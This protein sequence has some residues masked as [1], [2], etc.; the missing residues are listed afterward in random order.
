VSRARLGA[1]QLTRLRDELS[2]RDLGIVAQVAELRLMDARQIEA[3]HFGEQHHASRMTATRTCRRVLN[4]LV[5]RRV[6]ARLDRRVGGVRA[7]SASYVYTLGSVGQRVLALDG[8]RRRFREP[9]ATFVDHT[10]AIGQLVVS[11]TVAA[12]EGAC[13][14]LAVEA[15]PACWR[16][17]GA[18]GGRQ[19]LRPDLFVSL[20]VGDYDYRWL[21]EMDLGSESLPVVIRKCRVYDSYYRSG[22]EQTKHGVFPR[23]AWL[24]PDEHRA[25]RLREAIGTS[26]DLDGRLFTVATSGAAVRTL[27]GAAG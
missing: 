21:V 17:F 26:S 11:L 7:G 25:D 18:L 8:P 15:E 5:E 10:L 24:V 19:V 16:P 12:Q 22:T 9:T 14:L 13:D 23:V 20:G 27:I 3:L 2:E 1:L 6:L 4:R